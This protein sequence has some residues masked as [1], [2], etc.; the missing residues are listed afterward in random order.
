MQSV[1][2]RAGYSGGGKALIAVHDA[3]GG[4]PWGAYGFNLKHKHLPEMGKWSKV[5]KA[6]VFCPAVGG[7]EQGMVV[8]VRNDG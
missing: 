6:P 8:S 2:L 5:V 3:G 7:F 1:T 4:E